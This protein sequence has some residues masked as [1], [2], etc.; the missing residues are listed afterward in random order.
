M[1]A[2]RAGRGATDRPSATACSAGNSPAPPSVSAEFSGIFPLP[3]SGQDGF[4]CVL[5]RSGRIYR[6]QWLP[7][8]AAGSELHRVPAGQPDRPSGVGAVLDVD[9]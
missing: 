2:S 7:A 5:A 4:G 1:S 3:R 9:G 6:Q 8:R